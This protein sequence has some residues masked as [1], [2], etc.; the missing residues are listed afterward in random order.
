MLTW[1]G[2]GAVERPRVVQIRVQRSY[3]GRVRAGAPV[4]TRSMTC[5]EVLANVR[6]FAAGGPKAEQM[7]RETWNEAQIGKQAIAAAKSTPPTPAQ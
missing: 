3:P 4:P 2:S 5:E 6:Y 7:H 1:T